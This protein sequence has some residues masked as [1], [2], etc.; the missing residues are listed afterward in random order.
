M[1][2]KNGNKKG[3]ACIFVQLAYNKHRFFYKRGN[4][5]DAKKIV[6]EY[7]DTQIQELKQGMDNLEDR[8]KQPTHSGNL[9]NGMLKHAVSFE[10]KHMEHMR[11]ELLNLL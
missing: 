1:K 4:S 11:E 6:K 2:Y 8:D 7:M 5:M 3:T 10:I 9:Y